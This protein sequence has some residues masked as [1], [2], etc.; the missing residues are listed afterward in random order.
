MRKLYILI[1]LLLFA[2]TALRSQD[3]DF[4][5][6]NTIQE[7][8]ISFSSNNWRFALDSL[9][10]NGEKMLR[11]TVRINGTT[12]ADVGVRYRSGRA[13][14]PGGRRNGLYLQLDAFRPGQTFAGQ[15]AIDLSSALRD[16]S[17][18]REVLALELA[19]NY[20]AAPRA[21]YANVSIN[22][23]RYGLFVNQ[24][25]VGPVLLQRYFGEHDGALYHAD[26]EL[27]GSDQLPAGC[28]QQALGSL[29]AEAHTGCYSAGFQ[30]RQGNDYAALGQLAQRLATGKDI[31]ELLNVDAALWM[32]ALNNALVNLYS[33]SGQ[34]A[35]NYYLYRSAEGRFEPIL[36]DMNLAFGS[37]K[38][39][40]AVPSDLELEALIQLD[41]LLH[42]D[43]AARPLIRS[44]LA[45]DANRK[46][47]L[48][49]LRTLL[50]EQF[51]Q[52]R[53]A[54]RA[55]ELQ[56]FIRPA[57]A[58]DNNRYYSLEEFDRSLLETIG[59]RSRIPGL[60]D[61]MDRRVAWLKTQ[62]VYTIL[63][64]AITEVSVEKRERLASEQ[65]AE[66]RVR[67]RVGDYA[68]G[69]RLHYRFEE[70]HFQYVPMYDDGKHHDGAAN[71]GIYG[72][73]VIPADGA[74]GASM[75]YYIAA[76]NV[77][78]VGYSPS[79]YMFE[80]YRTTLAELNQ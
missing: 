5:A 37:Y 6:I 77:K 10:F 61:F 72:A 14:T 28:L 46:A 7:I 73:A 43:N 41:P 60:T 13:F 18:V 59:K 57:L 56:A 29:Q 52:D 3:R 20:M 64:P 8:D 4:Y 70:G 69:V 63:P 49:H 34:Y 42:V 31:G 32:L 78:A 12:L 38:N 68:K 23:E 30:L 27:L 65:L 58:Q 2:G 67:A 39:T 75:Q 25:P 54:R 21:N 1:A 80:Q 36:G 79:R 15:R 22:G 45:I 66:Y 47:Y 55:R 40:G 11:A 16:P 26:T 33:Y 19:R 48:H 51:A 35:Y 74:P 62:E 24:E 53:F 44:L 76:E 9:R 17:L 50:V 71:D